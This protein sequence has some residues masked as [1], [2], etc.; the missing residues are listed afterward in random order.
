MVASSGALSEAGPMRDEEINVT[1]Q[2]QAGV[3][4]RSQA[5]AHALTPGAIRARVIAGRWQRLHPG[6]YLT[7]SGPPTRMSRCWA[8]LLYC[9]DHAMLSHITAAEVAG[10]VDR[11]DGPIHVTVPHRQH[12]ARQPGLVI[13][14]SMIADQLRHPSRNPPQTRIEETV[15]EL[16]RLATGPEQAAGWVLRACA[17][18]VTTVQRLAA[19][20]GGRRRLRW[21]SALT[22]ALVDAGLG[23]ESVLEQRYLH[24]VERRHRLPDGRRQ[25]RVRSAGRVH[26]DDVRYRPWDVV[27]ELDG[28]LAHPAEVRPR[29]LDR[30]NDSTAGGAVVLRFGWTDVTV[31][32]C[33]VA[34]RVADALRRAGW[35]GTPRGCGPRC[36]LTGR[37]R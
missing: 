29:D 22:A 36:G 4:S 1:A 2:G 3:V 24:R 23:C 14:R 19:A 8:A 34:E 33:L 15:I 30:D 20:I 6:V 12:V 9:G 5:R 35:T 7:H 13:H 21:R 18:R 11:P 28:H 31:R 17:R 27:V 16:T 25:H 26:Y 10:L 32:T 37:K